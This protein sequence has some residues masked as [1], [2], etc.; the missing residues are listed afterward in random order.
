MENEKSSYWVHLPYLVFDGDAVKKSKQNANLK[1]TK[2]IQAK[3]EQ[4]KG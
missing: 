3:A 1:W 2:A 4:H